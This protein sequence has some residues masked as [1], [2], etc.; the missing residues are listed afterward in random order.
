MSRS[1]FLVLPTHNDTF[2]LAVAEALCMGLPVVT[3]HD[4]ACADLIDEDN[5][6][7]VKIRDVESLTEGLRRL[8]R[9]RDRYDPEAIAERARSRF[10]PEAMA[11]WYDGLFR[12]VIGME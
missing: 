8:I 5:G 7:L 12:R 6:K 1:D 9:D 4:T 3:T 10:S 11:T 2:G